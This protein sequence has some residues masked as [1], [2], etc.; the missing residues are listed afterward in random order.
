MFLFVGIPVTTYQY[1]P[2]DESPHVGDFSC[3]MVFLGVLDGTIGEEEHNVT[4]DGDG[5]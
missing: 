5:R 2:P 4:D 1:T 3:Q